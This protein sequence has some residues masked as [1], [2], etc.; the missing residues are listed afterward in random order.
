[1]KKTVLLITALFQF[2]I[3]KAQ[4][5]YDTLSIG[6]SNWASTTIQD[7]L[8]D[9][10]QHI[11]I[12]YKSVSNSSTSGIKK[13]DG[14]IWTQY[15]S[16]NSGLPSNFVYCIKQ[17]AQNNY[18]IG[19][20]AG[21]AKFDGTTWTVFN[22][23]NSAIISDTVNDILIDNQDILLATEKGVCKYNNSSWTNYPTISNKTYSLLKVNDTLYAGHKYSISVLN[24]NG[25]NQFT[26]ATTMLNGNVNKIIYNS[27]Y[28]IV[29]SCPTGI[30][31]F[32]NNQFKNLEDVLKICTG[33][34]RA[35]S[36]I[37]Y[38]KQIENNSNGNLLI[39]CLAPLNPTYLKT[40][41]EFSSTTYRTHTI[42]ANNTTFNLPYITFQRGKIIFIQI[43]GVNVPNK[44]IIVDAGL[45]NTPFESNNLLDNGCNQSK[46]DVNQVNAGMLP[47]G[48][49][50][51]DL[52]S[53]PR[54]EVPKNSGSQATFA[55]SIW[56]G[57]R[58]NNQLRTACQTYR[59]NGNDFWPG[60]LDTTN[61]LCPP[62]SRLG[63]IHK[64]NQTDI[65]EFIYHFNYGNVQNGT[66]TP[67][68]GIKY[69][70][71][72]D[73][74]NFSRNNAPFVDVN[75]NGIYDPLT[76]GDY[77]KIKGDQMLYHIY[78][79]A[80]GVHTETNSSGMMG[81]EIHQSSF[82]YS[83]SNIADSLNA[84]NYTTFYEFEIINRSDTLVDST[85]I[86]FWN[87]VDL[88]NYQDDYLGC[89]VKENYG[90][91]YNGDTYDDDGSGIV[92][93]H[94]YLPCFSTA[95]IASPPA[96]QNDGKDNNHN[97]TIDEANED[98]GMSSFML[99][100]NNSSIV[101]GNPLS[102][103]AHYYNYLQ[104]K[105]KDGST[106]KYGTNGTDGSVS[107]TFMFPG[108]SD[109][110]G[111]GLGGSINNPI[112]QNP[113]TETS[114][115]NVPG[116][117]RFIIGS[118]PFRIAPKDTAKIVYAMVFSVD[119][120]VTGDINHNV[121]K[122]EQ[123]VRR[124]RQW[125]KNN[126]FTTCTNNNT[127][128]VA[129]IKNSNSFIKAYPNP[130]HD[131]YTIEKSVFEFAQLEIKDILGKTLLADEMRTTK[132]T[133]DVSTFAPGIYFIKVTT[134][135]QQQ[136]IKVIKQ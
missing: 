81:L 17:D 73:T 63:N 69:W 75:Q 124:I 101:N 9:H 29:L 92:G 38:F 121:I 96:F 37:K 39:N 26:I 66:F 112:P 53:N 55:G 130:T 74:G 129:T 118:G 12:A 31:Q 64:V 19:T 56:I 91:I 119:S 16:S 25:T 114:G 106:L 120:A 103:P 57:G 2:V 48:D 34:I 79:D 43:V 59:Q 86:G 33:S 4:V 84:L 100:N 44:V 83:C 98:V 117:R 76:G 36:T 23:A 72:H 131:F 107:T 93:Y 77:P 65:N 1:M 32:K 132:H 7:V 113:W 8:L 5:A 45:L 41:S 13:F 134:A 89:N 21:L 108:D 3:T 42:Q 80:G 61:A 30:Y 87:D 28:G 24:Q 99:I 135:N 85:Y 111:F 127:V 82:A 128:N 95:I 20:T 97:G 109:P 70:P 22:R 88:G 62:A 50:F 125:Y 60:P 58:V 126:Q 67:S 46:L 105:W 40:F 6:G 78:N 102:D 94:E 116:D 54:Y 11:W 133:V 10:Q 90:Y 27:I 51:W 136:T 68:S 115:G 52:N 35:N 122:S 110:N 14:T 47:L 123:D 18:W 49:M 71:A 104:G 15:Q